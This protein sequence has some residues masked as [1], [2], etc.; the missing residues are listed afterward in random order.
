MVVRISLLSTAHVHF[1]LFASAVLSC[2]GVELTGIY[3]DCKER[4][5]GKA[6]EYR[7]VYFHAWEEAL[8][9]SEAVI[10]CSE[11]AKHEELVI[12]ALEAKKHVLCEKPL[13]TTAKSA[14]WMA[15]KADQLNLVLATAFPMR[16]NTP[17]SEMKKAIEQG[18]IGSIVAFHGT[19][20]GQ[21]P[22]GW[23]VD[24]SLAGGGAVMDHTV[25]LL[26]MMRW[27]T[28]AEVTRVYA[29][30]DSFLYSRYEIDDVGHIQLE[31]SNEV[32]ADIDTSWSRP[33]GFPAWGGL[34]LRATGTEGTIDLDGFAQTIACYTEQR[35]NWEYW[36]D[37]EYSYMIDGFLRRIGNQPTQL[38]SAWDGAAAVRVVEAA[39]LS[40]R[41]GTAVALT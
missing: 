13:S 33:Q 39:Y 4:G 15:G 31:F 5:K 29:E 7:T 36:G 18:W 24:Q 40:A 41:E 11:N 19:N 2:P 37:G 8:N 35:A 9:E 27:Y 14:E 1:D 23:F 12:A 20:Q 3:D 25:H 26:D 32:I 6:D 21:C 16:F 38:A 28:G 10:V 17:A 30:I 22:G 34:T